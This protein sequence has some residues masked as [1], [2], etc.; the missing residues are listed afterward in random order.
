MLLP[1]CSPSYIFRPTFVASITPCS[2]PG[3]IESRATVFIEDVLY[4]LPPAIN[5]LFFRSKFFSSTYN[6]FA[7]ENTGTV[8]NIYDGL[9]IIRTYPVLS[10]AGSIA[11]LRAKLEGTYPFPYNAPDPDIEMSPLF[12]VG[13]Y[14]VRDTVRTV[15]DDTVGLFVFTKTFLSGGSG[16]PTDDSG[17]ALIRTGPERSIIIITTTEDIH[18]NIITP[19]S[20]KR[21]QQWNGSTWI[22]YCNNVP[23]QCPLEGTC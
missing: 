21:I 19:P 10:G 16:G 23:G 15:E 3:F 20:N 2:A 12:P 14:D 11:D 7:V 1:S 6:N 9:S 4:P 13:D 5:G 17:L 8:F 18:G 22:S